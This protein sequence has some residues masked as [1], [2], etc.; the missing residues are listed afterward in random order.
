MNDEDDDDDDPD[1]PSPVTSHTSANHQGFIFGLSSQNVDMLSLHPPAEH[2]PKYWKVYKEN[3]DPL[4]K[5]IHV[6]TTEPTIL[7][8]KDHLE[9]IPRGLE[10][11]LFAIYYGAVTSMWPEETREMFG[12]DKNDLLARYR[13]GIEQSL[14]RADFL[15]SDEYIVLQAFVIFL[16]CLRRNDDARVIWTLTGLVVRMAQTLGIHRDGSHFDLPAFDIEMRRRLWWQICILDSRASE[17]HGC[18]PTINDHNFDTQMPLNVNDTDLSPDMKELPEAKIG[19]TEMTFGLIRF[20]ITS[21]LRRIQ[22]VPPGP[23]RCTRFFSEATVERKEQWIR[24]CHARLEERYLQNTDMSVPLYWVSYDPKTSSP[25]FL[26]PFQ[27]IATVS[28]LIMSKMWLIIYHPFQ[29]IDGG[30]S[31]PQE[32]RDKLFETSL[33]NIEYSLLLE[34]EEKTR[35]WGWLFRTYVQW[36]AIAFLLSEL[37]VRTTGPEVERAWRAI[38]F[39]TNRKWADDLA[40]NKLKSHLWKPLKKLMAIA[41]AERDKELEI[42]RQNAQLQLQAQAES[43]RLDPIDPIMSVD[44]G[45]ERLYPPELFAGSQSNGFHNTWVDPFN[46]SANI[47]QISAAIPNNFQ[48]SM[49]TATG[50]DGFPLSSNGSADWTNFGVTDPSQTSPIMPSTGSVD[51]ENWDNLVQEFGMEVDQPQQPDGAPGPYSST[52][53]GITQWY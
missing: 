7:G 30:T 6:P 9:K 11:L 21:V 45:V 49:P 50:S 19:C 41:K 35:R 53:G 28:R 3:V 34:T 8:A 24:E 15:Q 14:A 10:A 31:L 51:W 52:F 5:I 4:A 44:L 18:D 23:K 36:H 12:E 32:T 37:R 47:G 40:T 39:V 16:I 33:E 27:V 13:F 22:Y 1:Y 17:D 48:T 46:P 26:T 42:E 25:S 20:E 43:Q 2:V 38:E 29:R